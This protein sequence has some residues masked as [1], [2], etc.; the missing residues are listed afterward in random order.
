M[1]HQRGTQI[2]HETLR[3]RCTKFLPSSLKVQEPASGRTSLNFRKSQ[4]LL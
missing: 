2:S 4:A 3:E 1:L